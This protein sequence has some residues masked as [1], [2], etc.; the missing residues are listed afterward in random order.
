MSF[1]ARIAITRDGTDGFSSEGGT[2]PL[3]QE[4]PTEEA[5]Y[6]DYRSDTPNNDRTNLDV[7][8]RVSPL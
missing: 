5:N 4:P 2:E 8:D 6:R 1:A 7:P 3:G